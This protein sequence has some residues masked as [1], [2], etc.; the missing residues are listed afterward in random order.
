MPDLEWKEM[1]PNADSLKLKFCYQGSVPSNPSALELM[2]LA[3]TVDAS[4]KQHTVNCLNLMPNARTIH[5]NCDRSRFYETVWAE[6]NICT[7]LQ[8]CQFKK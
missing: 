3:T 8:K 6:S 7:K 5:L 1:F 4:V 2:R